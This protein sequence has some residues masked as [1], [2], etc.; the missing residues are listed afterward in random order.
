M[1]RLT[2]SVTQSIGEITQ[3]FSLRCQFKKYDYEWYWLKLILHGIINIGQY[4][5]TRL[6]QTIKP[7]SQYQLN[8]II[9]ENYKK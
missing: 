7:I 2:D 9:A 1:H 5:D 8:E 3:F 4:L 6:I